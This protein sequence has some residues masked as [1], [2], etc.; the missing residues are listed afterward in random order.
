MS[1]PPT[2]YAA[3]GAIALVLAA[4]LSACGGSSSGVPN[5]TAAVVNGT[6][7]KTA[8]FKHWLAVLAGVKGT[9]AAAL[10]EPP[11]F[12]A[13]IKALEAQDAEHHNNRSASKR[14][15]ACQAEYDSL[16]AQALGFLITSR[17][18]LSEAKVLG[19][20]VPEKQASEEFAKIK[21]E[22]FKTSAEFQQYL[23]SSGQTEA[24][25]IYRLELNLLEQKLEEKVAAKKP[26]VSKAQIENYYRHTTVASGGL[27]EKRDVSLVLT[28]NRK[29]AEE[30]KKE[31]ES[32]KSFASVAK[33][34]SVDAGSKDEGGYVPAIRKGLEP[35]PFDAALFKAKMHALIGPIKTPN[36]YY[37][38]Q[39]EKIKPAY[40]PSLKVAESAIKQL[41]T[42]ERLKSAVAEFETAYTNKWKAKTE[43]G[44]EY[45]VAQCKG[46]KAPASGTGTTT[47]P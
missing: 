22:K 3:L 26:P 42:H 1:R 9:A 30:A 41:L 4:G 18:A 27:P 10:P 32:G 24:D 23:A 17:W 14:K 40:L 13:C 44:P 37:V 7:I 43:C 19:V 29:D 8:T 20:P 36:G 16:R 21:K 6:P 5:G 11:N 47:A 34:R 12:T 39:V 45:M 25:I 35:Q 46:Y 38:F 2:R 31:I 28:K 33:A 15:L